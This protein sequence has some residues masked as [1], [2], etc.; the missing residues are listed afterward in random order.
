[1][2]L[3]FFGNHVPSNLYKA[4]SVLMEHKAYPV[5]Q[6]HFILY[7]VLALHDASV[8]G[9]AEVFCDPGDFAISDGGEF[10][11]SN[12]VSLRTTF[13]FQGV[14]NKSWFAKQNFNGPGLGSVGVIAMC[15]DNPPLR[16]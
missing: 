10:T 13:D 15:L 4:Q 12:D 6:V 7:R 16:L 14:V 11:A 5:H 9:I 8:E 1:M 3:N 2:S